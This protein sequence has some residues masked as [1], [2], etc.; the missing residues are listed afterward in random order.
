MTKSRQTDAPY[1]DGSDTFADTKR[2]EPGGTGVFD[3]LNPMIT[4]DGPADAVMK[5]KG[6]SAPSRKIGSLL[7]CSNTSIW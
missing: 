4:L 3:K 6:L 1:L 2:L 5:E 7:P